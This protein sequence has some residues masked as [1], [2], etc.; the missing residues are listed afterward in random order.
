CLDQPPHDA[1]GT[2]GHGRDGLAS[3]AVATKRRQVGP[4]FPG[5]L[6]AVDVGPDPGRTEHPDVDQAHP[7]P[8]GLEPAAQDVVLV[9]FRVQR[10]DQD[11]PWFGLVLPTHLIAPL[12]MPSSRRRWANRKTTRIGSEMSTLNAIRRP[13][14]VPYRLVC[15]TSS[16]P[17]GYASGSVRNVVP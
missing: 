4:C 3:V 1:C 8:G 2:V 5:D 13:H 6:L 7:H 17:T 14:W 15:N 12:N 10:P 16:A 11:H 9:A